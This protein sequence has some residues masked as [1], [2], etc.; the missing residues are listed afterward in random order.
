VFAGRMIRTAIATTVVAAGFAAAAQTAPAATDFRWYKG[1]DEASTPSKLDKVGVL[2]VGPRKAKKILILNPGTSGAAAYFYP[3]AKLITKKT[4]NWQV[5]S[6]E[7][8]GTQLE[9]QSVFDQVK[10]GEAS[11]GE[12]FDYYLNWLTDPTITDH[13]EFI[14]DSEVGFGREWGMKVAVKD[15]KRVVKRANRKARTVVMGGHSLGGSIT[16]A[17]ATWDFNG[18]PGA[19]GL[20]GLAFID[21]GSGPDPSLTPAEATDRLNELAAG[22]PWLSF[23]GIDAPFSG[24]FNSVGADLALYAPKEPSVLHTW[25]LLPGNLKAPVPPTNR[26]GYGYALDAE[27]S[28]SSLVAAQVNAGRLAKSGDPRDWVRAGEISPLR[29]VAKAFAAPNLPGMDGTAW[30]HPTRLNLDSGGVAAGNDN[31]TQDVLDLN[32]IHGDDLGPMPIYAFGA[33]LGGQRV[34]DA[35]QALADQSSIPASKLRLV[36]RE[37][38]YTHIDPLTA[39]PKNEFVRTLRKFLRGQVG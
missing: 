31:P 4:T 35:A 24:L 1:Y 23:G 26:A 28:P 3:L 38:A 22:S 13:F 2:K 39:Q 25:P 6:I 21:G 36:N 11:V 15:L 30:Y 33:A 17:Y 19:A 18:K 14:P 9:D 12:M 16:T 10:R 20:D 7:R 8:R 5:W 29:R 37:N 27:T 32:A 34:L